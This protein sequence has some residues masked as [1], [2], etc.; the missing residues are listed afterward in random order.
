MTSS[1][2]LVLFSLLCYLVAGLASCSKADV[3]PEKEMA[4]LLVGRWKAVKYSGGITGGTFPADPARKQEIIFSSTGQ[5]LFLLNGT[6]TSTSSYALTQVISNLT[7]KTETFVTYGGASYGSR[8]EQLTPTAL[9]LAD[10]FPD[11][12]GITYQR[13]P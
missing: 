10:D 3:S 11:G 7:G 5:A 13:V 6:V 1:L 4:T 9:G 2:R 8:L 12:F